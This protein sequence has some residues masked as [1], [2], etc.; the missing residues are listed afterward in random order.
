L[1]IRAGLVGMAMAFMASGSAR[2]QQREAPAP[3]IG[4]S[5]RSFESDAELQ[6]Y[7]KRIELLALDAQ[8]REDSGWGALCGSKFVL[9]RR[10]MSRQSTSSANVVI[11]VGVSD[12]AGETVSGALLDI[13]DSGVQT[14]THE[15]GEAML[16]VPAGKIPNSHRLSLR[17]R[18]IAYNFRRGQFKAFAGDT[19]DIELSLCNNH[20]V[21]QQGVSAAGGPRG[22]RANFGPAEQSDV[23]AGDDVAVSGHF[24]VIL[25]RGRLYS[26]DLGPERGRDRTLRLVG[27]MNL[28]SANSQFRPYYKLMLRG[29]RIIVVGYH[30]SEREVEVQLLHLADDGVLSRTASYELRVDCAHER[31]IARLAGD[32]LVL[33]S[34][35][36]LAAGSVDALSL[37]PAVKRMIPDAA[38]G[39]FQSLVTASRMFRFPNDSM[40]GSAPFLNTVTMCDVKPSALACEA[41]VIIGP[42]DNDYRV[43]RTAFYVWTHEGDQPNVLLPN[44]HPVTLFRVPLSE[45]APQ[46]IRLSGGPF[47]HLSLNEDARGGLRLFASGDAR[48]GPHS[49]LEGGKRERAALFTLQS[50]DFG[51]GTRDAPASTHRTVPLDEGESVRS[52][53]VGSW[54]F[55]SVGGGYFRY[56]SPMTTLFAI[57]TD[58]GEARRI[59]LPYYVERIAPMDSDAIVIATAAPFALH[60]LR[61]NPFSRSPLSGHFVL[62]N[63]SQ[64]EYE[65]DGFFYRSIDSARGL[66]AIPGRGYGRSDSTH[67]ATGST[68]VEFVRVS[69]R[70]L[71]SIGSLSST[72]GTSEQD[73]L[74]VQSGW[75]EDWYGNARGLFVGQRIFALIGYELIEARMIDGRLVERQRI[76]FMPRTSQ[77]GWH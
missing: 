68:H 69:P 47:N 24:L 30:N 74:E 54:L 16:V 14:T 57:R 20:V 77:T 27:F 66:L 3:T 8:A 43:S 71:V 10:S 64:A 58:S 19:I 26:F 76:N 40:I 42:R 67:W 11:R 48:Y 5:L 46:A 44:E 51:D 12:T 1:L 13:D 45:H 50:S 65:R 49:Q 21:L 63:P 18:G 70:S 33:F 61:I 38:S 72:P 62:T 28:Y 55:Y 39:D 52:E 22:A 6:S 60:F 29:T 59:R 53:F 23:D 34:T 15:N 75:F 36:P 56:A 32:R 25:R 31:C 9:T 41:R 2:A 17:A 35:T 37:L 73:S 7:L 4:T